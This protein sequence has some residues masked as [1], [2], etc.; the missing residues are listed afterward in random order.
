MSTTTL[1]DPTGPSGKK[2]PS[3]QKAL[4]ATRD[5]YITDY[6]IHDLRFPT[7]LTGDGT[8]AMNTTCDYSAAYVKLYV[9]PKGLPRSSPPASV[10]KDGTLS[11]LRGHGVSAAWE[12]SGVRGRVC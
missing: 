5:L 2:G 7:S 12:R 1:V 8:D 11:E 4:D 3:Y 10:G 9:G 6:S